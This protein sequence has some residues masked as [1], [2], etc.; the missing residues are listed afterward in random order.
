MFQARAAIEHLARRAVAKSVRCTRATRGSA[1][2]PAR[3]SSSAAQGESAAPL[4]VG[5]RHGVEDAVVTLDVG[6]T[7][8]HTLRSTVACNEVLS[9]YVRRADANPALAKDGAVFVDRDPKHFG[10]LLNHLR[11]KTEGLCHRTTFKGQQGATVQLPTDSAAL[12]DIYLEAEF[13][14]MQELSSRICTK[15]VMTWVAK[16][17]DAS[18]NP[19]DSVSSV[20]NRLKRALIAAGSIFTAAAGANNIDHVQS[21]LHKAVGTPAIFKKFRLTSND[22]ASPAGAN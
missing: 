3:N 14:G 18:S 16:T 2:C 11:N 4:L 12:R 22:T 13:F 20:M 8:F 21:F 10:V 1:G 7:L 17:L 6:G 15:S 19:F 9:D 5:H